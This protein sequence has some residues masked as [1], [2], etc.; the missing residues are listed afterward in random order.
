M[1]IKL[2]VNNVLSRKSSIVIILFIAFTT[3]LFGIANAFFDSTDNGL[4]QSYI[5]SFTGNLIITPKANNQL[6]LFGD[7]TPVTGSLS[8]IPL[9]KESDKVK[10]TLNS[11]YTYTTQ[12]TAPCY[13]EKDKK[14]QA[15]YLFGINPSEYLNMMTGLHIIEGKAF[16]DDQRGVLISKKVQNLLEVNIGDRI[17]FVVSDGPTLRIRAAEVTGIY[18]SGSNLEGIGQYVLA[19]MT[20]AQSLLGLEK[21]NKE[22]VEISQDKTDLLDEDFDLDSIFDEDFESIEEEETVSS[23]SETIIESTDET[24][25]YAPCNFIIVS[26]KDSRKAG[27]VI[28]KL[29]KSF[30]NNNIN[31]VATD[32]RH[33]AGSSALYLYWIRII[34]NI[35]ICII[36]ISGYIIINN[37]LVINIMDRTREIGT[38]RAFGTPKSY[39]SL[40]CFIE[41]AILTIS[42]GIIGLVLAFI[43]TTVI[44]LAHIKLTN[45]FLIQL[46]GSSALKVGITHNNILVLL[47]IIA[48]LC[49]AGWI[50]P[51][52]KAIKVTPVSAMK[53]AK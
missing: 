53:E 23:E 22:K 17:Q 28:K 27:S 6:S 26:L 37:T 14:R 4:Q 5:A 1:L 47:G 49:L 41:T 32:W 50:L 9:L 20:T 35:G 24:S 21:E 15:L 16:E 34:F 3:A 40:E 18:E 7:E 31:A 39:V 2:A 30:K 43:G 29:N 42:G 48:L 13:V 10:Q 46:F 25:V 45:S 44:T 33:A 8:K 38:M 19:D 36:L 52:K 11:T 51:V 12:L